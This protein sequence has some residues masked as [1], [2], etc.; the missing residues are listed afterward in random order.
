MIPPLHV[1]IV[2][3]ATIHFFRTP[4]KDGRPD[5]PSVAWDDLVAAFPLTAGHQGM[6]R[7]RLREEWGDKSRTIA[8]TAGVVVIVPYVMGQGFVAGMDDYTGSNAS[9]E[10]ETAA[11][12][13]MK[14][15][16]R[17]L[18]YQDR[19]LYAVAGFDRWDEEEPPR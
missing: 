6:M 8:S 19:L 10:Y 5:L 4:L 16:L 18:P 7:Q 13:A 3:D 14:A 1:G 2:N 11:A 9:E 15:M 12:C 17:N